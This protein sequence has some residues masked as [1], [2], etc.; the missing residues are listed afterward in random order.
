MGFLNFKPGIFKTL[1]LAFFKLTSYHL[2]R[3]SATPLRHLLDDHPPDTQTLSTTFIISQR[4]SQQSIRISASVSNHD[5]SNPKHAAHSTTSALY[6]QLP[7]VDAHA[8]QT[9]ST[10]R[11]H[12]SIFTHDRLNLQRTA[13]LIDTNTQ[14]RPDP[15]HTLAHVHSTACT[16]ARSLIP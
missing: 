15:Q 6:H 14:T 3:Y 8:R 4:I 10:V 5:R 7:P 12:H 2:T 9:K 1:N 11:S 13:P 16:L